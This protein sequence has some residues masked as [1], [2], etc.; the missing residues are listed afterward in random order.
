MKNK[1]T[2]LLIV[3]NTAIRYVDG[4]AGQV[5][6]IDYTVPTIISD[7]EYFRKNGL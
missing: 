1:P 7:L 5:V 4:I 2:L 3:G 6:T